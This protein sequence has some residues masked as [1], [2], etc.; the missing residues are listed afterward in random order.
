MPFEN[1]YIL[2]LLFSEDII[3]NSNLPFQWSRLSVFLGSVK[4]EFAQILQR[5]T[6]TCQ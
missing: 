3:S 1:V 6:L 4:A 2:N 5:N